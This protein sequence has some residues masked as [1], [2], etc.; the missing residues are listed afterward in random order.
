MEQTSKRKIEHLRLCIEEDVESK[1]G[2][3]EDITLIHKALPEIDKN[4]IDLSIDFLGKQFNAPILIASITGGHPDTKNINAALAG[5]AEEMG[6][7]M[8]VGSQ[9]AALEDPKQEDSFR[10]VRDAAPSAFIYAN[11]GAPQLKGYGIEGIDK[12]VEMIDAD[13]VAIHLNFLQEA[14]QPEGDTDASGCLDM[15]K[16]ICAQSSVPVMVKETGAGISHD[17]AVALKKAGVSAIDV[18]GYGGMNFVAVEVCRA[19]AEGDELLEHLGN[20]FWDWGIP[21][22]TSIVESSVGIPIVA[23]GGVRTGMDMAKCLALGASLCGTALPLIVPA[24]KGKQG[25]IDKLKIMTEELRT[26]AFLTGCRS[27]TDMG[28]TQIVITGRTR[29][30]LEQRGFNIGQ[31]SKYN[32]GIK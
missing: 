7:G 17:V 27:V 6:I 20:V 25:I 2:G 19:R 18:G 4:K 30:I 21:T 10:I 32:G 26:A 9:R 23:T 13:A 31:F 14:I 1:G 3:F 15:I 11:V 16:E 12:T 5:A 28:G 8:G 24:R 22:T 29:E